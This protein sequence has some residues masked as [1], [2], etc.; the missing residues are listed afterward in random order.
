VSAVGALVFTTLASLAFIAILWRMEEGS[1]PPVETWW[2]IVLGRCVTCG[3]RRERHPRCVHCR[4]GV[5][6]NWHT[7]HGCAKSQ[8]FARPHG[9]PRAV[10]YLI[11]K[12][13]A[14]IMMNKLYEEDGLDPFVDE[15]VVELKEKKR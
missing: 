1:W 3:H 13:A 12:E 14:H 2:R 7:C 6:Y 4:A 10:N 5:Y 15:I 11:Q 9:A 8:N